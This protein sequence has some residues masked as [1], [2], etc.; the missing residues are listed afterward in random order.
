SAI[1]LPPRTPRRLRTTLLTEQHLTCRAAVPRGQQVLDER[2][3]HGASGWRLVAQASPGSQC[4]NG[5]A[6]ACVR[7]DGEGRGG[8]K[9]Q[10]R[11]CRL[12]LTRSLYLVPVGTQLAPTEC[13]GL[14]F[15]R[16]PTC[17]HASTRLTR[18]MRSSRSNG[19]GKIGTAKRSSRRRLAAE[20]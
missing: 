4:H 19:S 5:D 3:A 2:R 12:R 1:S 15:A 14:Y 6:P 18:A 13:S 17:I 10:H 20:R 7:S 16:L 11:P 9:R 8:S